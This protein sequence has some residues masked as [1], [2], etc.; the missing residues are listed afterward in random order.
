MYNMS[1]HIVYGRSQLN[2]F[3]NKINII[4]F[5]YSLKAYVVPR[6]ATLKIRWPMAVSSRT[7]EKSFVHSMKTKL[8]DMLV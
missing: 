5:K 7:T 1:L 8:M 2:I 3:S 6:D 4:K